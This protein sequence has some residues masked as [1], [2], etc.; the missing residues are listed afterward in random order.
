M[1]RDKIV[2]IATALPREAYID[3]LCAGAKQIEDDL[4]WSNF[5]DLYPNMTKN[6]AKALAEACKEERKEEED[7]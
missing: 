1:N 6:Q 5:W 3:L 7:E 4:K 2:E